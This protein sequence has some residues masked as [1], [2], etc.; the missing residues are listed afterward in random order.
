MVPESAQELSRKQL[1][2]IGAHLIELK[3][4]APTSPAQP[5]CDQEDDRRHHQVAG[6]RFSGRRSGITA[7]VLANDGK[8]GRCGRPLTS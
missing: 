2:D 4:K 8:S 3:K 5:F 1:Q 6:G 7:R